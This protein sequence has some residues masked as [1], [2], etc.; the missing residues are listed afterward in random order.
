VAKK[1]GR[2]ALR[3]QSCNT[4]LKKSWGGCPRCGRPRLARDQAGKAVG[5][6]A[7]LAKGARP[8]C[9]SCGNS[10]RPGASY[11]SG[12]GRV[13]LT[14]IKSADAAR[15][16]VFMDKIRGSHNPEER[17]SYWQLMLGNDGAS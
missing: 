9:S 3:C 12:C 2:A 15:R 10:S 1:R 8:R 4:K 16:E 5:T 7:F 14:V 11:C 17:E 6:V 13:M